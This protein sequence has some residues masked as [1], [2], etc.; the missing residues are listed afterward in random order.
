MGRLIAIAAVAAAVVVVTIWSWFSNDA[1]SASPERTVT[2]VVQAKVD[3]K[4]VSWWARRAR[5][6]GESMRALQHALRQRLEVDESNWLARGFLCIQRFETAP[7]FPAWR[8]ATGNGYFGGVQMDIEFQRRYG[9]EFL[10]AWG[11]ADHWPPF[12]Q[13]A[14]AI[15][16]YLS[17]RGFYPWPHTARRCG[18]L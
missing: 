2:V 13:V 4:D 18:L 7:P 3:G 5:G 12:V 1:F 8:T 10:K 16:A 17:G 11:T 9:A 14:V 15:R 6:N